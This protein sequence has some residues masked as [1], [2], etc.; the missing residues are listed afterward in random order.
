MYDPEI[1]SQWFLIKTDRLPRGINT[2]TLNLYIIPHVM[3]TDV[4]GLTFLN[5][6]I[7]S[8]QCIPILVSWF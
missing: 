4:S 2:I 5:A 6:G 8:F 7:I 1:E 3:M